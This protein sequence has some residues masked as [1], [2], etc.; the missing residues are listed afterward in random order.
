MSNVNGYSGIMVQSEVTDDGPFDLKE[1]QGRQAAAQR[2]LD[3]NQTYP[4]VSP[5][6]LGVIPGEMLVTRKVQRT[7]RRSG[8]QKLS[9]FS[10]LN[11][12]WWGCYKTKAGN[13]RHLQFCGIAKN[14]Y[15]MPGADLTGTARGTDYQTDSGISWLSSG[16]TTANRNTGP[17]VILAGDL[18][19]LDMPDTVP[20]VNQLG[21]AFPT[22]NNA[23]K[24]KKSAIT[25][26]DAL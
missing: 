26:R 14:L 3:K 19:F 23:G 6:N 16:A 12:Y 17:H 4:N 1:M 22:P 8:G 24:K 21:N 11:G 13:L 5:M 20:I 2:G 25:T 10:S 18:V 7:H 9:V 15:Q